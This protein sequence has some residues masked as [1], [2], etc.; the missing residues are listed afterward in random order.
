MGH[1]LINHDGG[2]VEDVELTT[3]ALAGLNQAVFDRTGGHLAPSQVDGILSM[4]STQ[5]V[6]MS[7]HQQS[8]TTDR[9]LD[10]T[11]N[12]IARSTTLAEQRAIIA[13]SVFAEGC[14]MLELHRARGRINSAL[15]IK[16]AAKAAL[17]TEQRRRADQRAVWARQGQRRDGRPNCGWRGDMVAALLDAWQRVGGDKTDPVH[18]NGNPTPL[19]RWLSVL[20][21]SVE[22][23]PVD[24][25]TLRAL[26]KAQTQT[27]TVDPMALFNGF[28]PYR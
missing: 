28:K 18:D 14:L 19:H 24:D 9:E 25:K 23:K 1:C 27:A 4:V 7:S 11:L 10:A 26:V 12:R 17:A 16:R 3:D 22:G 5:R 13:G 2:I 6:L 8:Q 20:F 21:E 15:D